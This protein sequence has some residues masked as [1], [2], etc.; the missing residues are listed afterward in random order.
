MSPRRCVDPWDWCV[1]YLLPSSCV[2]NIPGRGPGCGA[3]DHARGLLVE[4]VRRLDASAVSLHYFERTYPIWGFDDCRTVVTAVVDAPRFGR[5]R[6]TTFARYCRRSGTE[7]WAV[8][9]NGHHLNTEDRRH[10]P[11]Q[12]FTAFLVYCA[13][14]ARAP[15]ASAPDPPR[16]CG[17]A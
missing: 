4:L 11:S 6:V 1:S 5:V 10:P 3:H 13:L 14:R 7:S 8:F 17:L 2:T 9:V 16:E 12:R 15:A